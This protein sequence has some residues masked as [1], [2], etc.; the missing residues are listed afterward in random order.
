MELSPLQQR[1]IIAAA[2]AKTRPSICPFSKSKTEKGLVAGGET[3]SDIAAPHELVQLENAGVVERM[4]GGFYELTVRG[5][6]MAD[7]L[8]GC[9]RE[10]LPD[11]DPRRSLD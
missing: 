1:I 5:R 8:G 11:R 7:E 6:A 4:V 9:S 2:R 10:G 3:F